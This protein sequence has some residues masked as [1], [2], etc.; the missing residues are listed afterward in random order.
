MFG[1]E[2]RHAAGED[3]AEASAKFVAKGSV[4]LGFGGLAL[5]GGHLASDF[6]EDVVDAG[7]VETGSFKAQLRQ[8]LFGLEPCNSGSLFNDGATVVRLGGEKLADAL[9]ADDGVGLAAR[10]VPMKMS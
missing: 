5:K 6:V 2:L 9:L 10:P 8:A 4:T 7:E 3:H 1:I